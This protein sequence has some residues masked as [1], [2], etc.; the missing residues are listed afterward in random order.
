MIK[1]KTANNNAK[2]F[3]NRYVMGHFCAKT[4][5]IQEVIARNTLSFHMI[6]VSCHVKEATNRA[7]LRFLF[8]RLVPYFQHAV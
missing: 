5:K 1:N 3:L 2:T 6:V 4:A 8:A 7:C